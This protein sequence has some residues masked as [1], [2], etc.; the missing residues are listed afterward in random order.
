MKIYLACRYSGTRE[1]QEMRFLRVNQVA[2]KLMLQ[3]HI[4]FSPI[5]HS[6]PISKYIPQD[7]DTHE[8]WLGQD[9]SFLNWADQLWILTDDCWWKSV[10]VLIEMNIM[11]RQHKLIKYISSDEVLDAQTKEETN[12]F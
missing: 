12:S 3:G 10:G 4:V 6:H 7:S 8:F 1:E 11:S 5:S 2:A 9:Q